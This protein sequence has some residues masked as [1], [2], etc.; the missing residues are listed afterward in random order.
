MASMQNA[1]LTSDGT[2]RSV[3]FPMT[4]FAAAHDRRGRRRHADGA[5]IITKGAFSNVLGI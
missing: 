1:G 5:L 2:Q 4:L 3:K